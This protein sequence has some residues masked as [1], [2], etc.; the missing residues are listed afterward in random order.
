ME[1]CR[2]DLTISEKYISSNFV[3][4]L[5]DEF[6]I[7]GFFSLILNDGKSVLDDLFIHPKFIGKGYGRILWNGII[8]IAK[9]MGINEFSI[10]AD[11]HAEEFYRKMGAIRIGYVDSTVFKDRKLPLMKVIVK[12]QFGIE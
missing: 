6:R 2:N 9:E 12:S 10:D 7:I 1:A 5:E 8:K 11:P 3:Y 4:V